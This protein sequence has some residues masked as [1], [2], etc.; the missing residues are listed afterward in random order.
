MSSDSIQ[1][2]DG[3]KSEYW[4]DLCKY[5]LDTAK[6]MLKTKRYLYVGFMCH[7]V[8]EKAFK[9]YHSY[10]QKEDAP[11][12]HSLKKL[13]DLTKLSEKLSEEQINLLIELEGMNIEARYP[14]R[15]SELVQQLS[16]EICK[17]LVSNT[18]EFLKWIQ[19][20]LSV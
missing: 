7:Q 17:E 15:K 13:T 4:L 5:D 18:E 10:F 8:A 9:A 12:T 3:S 2:N 14:T 19:S 1:E 6:A 16:D 11:Y 20:K